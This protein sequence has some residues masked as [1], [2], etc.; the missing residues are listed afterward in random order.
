MAAAADNGTAPAAASGSAL[1][2]EQ[3]QAAVRKDLSSD[4]LH[5]Q[6]IHEQKRC[7]SM[8]ERVLEKCK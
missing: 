8:A 1:T 5:E 4:K 3:A 6:Y 7:I 2:G